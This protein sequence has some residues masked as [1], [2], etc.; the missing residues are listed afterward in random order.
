MLLLINVILTLWVSCANG[1]VRPCHFP[2]IKHGG[3]YYESMRRPYFPV[4]VGKYFS[5]Y[6]DESFE[7]PSGSY[8]DY[9]HCTQDGWSPA[10][11]CLR[12]CYFPY[13]ENGHN[14]NNGRKFVQGNSI[15]VAC[16]PGYGLRNE[17][18]TVNCTENG[19]SPPPRC[20]HVMR[21]CHFPDIKHGGLYYESMRRPYFPVAVGKY[22]SYYCDESFETPSGSYWDYIH[23]TQ[24]GWSPAVP[25]LR[26]C[27][28]PYL[29][30]G[31]NE[32]N[33][34]KFVQGNSIEVACHPGYGLPKEQTTVTC[35]ENG[36]SPPPRCIHVN[37]T[38]KCGP[39]PP[40]DNGDTTSFPLSLYAPDSSVEYQCQN[41]YQL[42]GNKRVTC[43]NG[44]WSEPPKCLYA[45]VISPEIMEKYNI[46][47]KWAAKQKLYS[48]TGEPVE[49]VC[50][51]GYHLSPNSHALRTTCQDGK[52][53]YPTCV[54]RY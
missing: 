34:R 9:I 36:W 31:H 32:N 10:V 4:A 8:W 29:E 17:Q 2:D 47:F 30:N 28:F 44:Q 7:T 18:T 41:L 50:R 33:G 48:R 35:T 39:P 54:K 25:C 23:C 14:E 40:I 49:F 11:P 51:S 1:Q 52:L 45:C 12:K 43:R 6:C 38:R 19:W 5:Y 15:E 20:I 37:S 22:F 53:E 27:Y 13:L 21:P 46:T 3:L 26:K 16:H 42:E 24:D